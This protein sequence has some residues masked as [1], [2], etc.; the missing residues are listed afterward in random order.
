MGYCG[1]SRERELASVVLSCRIAK[2]TRQRDK[3][4]DNQ[5]DHDLSM[6]CVPKHPLADWKLSLQYCRPGYSL[7]FVVHCCQIPIDRRMPASSN[8]GS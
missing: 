5:Y 1:L 7:E 4:I 6:S 3:S 8:V 2:I